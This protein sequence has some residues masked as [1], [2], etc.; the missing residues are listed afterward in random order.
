MP[1]I[2]V[3]K[4]SGSP[5]EMGFTH[6]KRYTN[7]IREI[8]AERIHLC[9]DETWTGRSMPRQD[10]LALAEK[11]LDAHYAYAPE[12]MRQLEGMADAT[13]L[14]LAEL[15]ITNG[16][17]DFV[18]VIYN[19]DA[20]RVEPTRIANECT[21][22]LVGPDMAQD[23]L[24]MLSQTWDMHATATPYVLL[25][26]GEPQ[27]EPA[28][29]AFT[30]TGCVGMIGMNEA[31][32]AVG[33]NNLVGADGKVGV[34]WPFVCRKILS[35]TNIEDALACITEAELAGGHNYLLMDAAGQGYNVEAMASAV[36]V[37][38]LDGQVLA[39][40]N[41]CLQPSTQAVERAP[42]DD[43]IEDSDTRVNRANEF[44]SQQSITPETL[45]ALTR[46]RTDGAYSVC[47][48]SEPPYY[49]ETCCAVV[50]RSGTHEF[51]GVWGLPTENDYERFVV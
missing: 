12:Q 8:T 24:G 42:M 14:S 41:Q 17:T 48:M 10:V 51:W 29:L 6:G 18:D 37:T 45:M 35:Q 19:M 1:P 46:D 25:L 30:I 32:I 5:Y 21:S 47:A 27:N 33:I 9:S 36:H 3:L 44:L 22:A 28:F 7:P 26:R 49:S 38:D 11:C 40:A 39:H 15:I 16:F 34:T 31:G 23:G 13:G 43:A 2:R 50:M 20:E 4:I